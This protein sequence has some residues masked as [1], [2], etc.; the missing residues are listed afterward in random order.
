MLCFCEPFLLVSLPD[1]FEVLLTYLLR[2][3][4]GA[5][6]FI[7]CFTLASLHHTLD[8]LFSSL[9]SLLY[10]LDLGSLFVSYGRDTGLEGV[11]V[12]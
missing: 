10:P 3:F 1:S 4:R 9:L 2:E 7:R 6:R 11:A 8:L 5:G 12:G